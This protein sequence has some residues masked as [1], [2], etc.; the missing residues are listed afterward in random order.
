MSISLRDQLRQARKE[1]LLPASRSKPQ[2]KPK[3]P[4]VVRFVVGPRLNTQSTSPGRP[5]V[6]RKPEKPLATVGVHEPEI[7]TCRSVARASQSGPHG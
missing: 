6:G 7:R 1:G 5:G 3:H 4:E 2:P